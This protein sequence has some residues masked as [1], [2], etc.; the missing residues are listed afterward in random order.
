ME[1]KSLTLTYGY[2]YR[3][4]MKHHIYNGQKNLGN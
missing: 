3:T 4:L 1:L 2:K